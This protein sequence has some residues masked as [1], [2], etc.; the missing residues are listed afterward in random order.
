MPAQSSATR[1]VVHRPTNNQGQDGIVGNNTHVASVRH[2]SH[3]GLRNFN[4][5]QFQIFEFHMPLPHDFLVSSTNHWC[6]N[7]TAWT[8]E[9]LHWT[10]R[11]QATGDVAKHDLRLE[12]SYLLVFLNSFNQLK[13][14]EQYIGDIDGAR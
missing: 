7:S 2:L 4:L 1:S 8:I 9:A 6:Q 3:K 13:V 5:L 12:K 10:H 14:M 11:P